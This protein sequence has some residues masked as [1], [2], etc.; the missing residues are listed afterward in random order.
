MKKLLVFMLAAA[1]LTACVD[2]PFKDIDKWPLDKAP[3]WTAGYWILFDPIL[4]SVD[5]SYWEPDTH[6]SFEPHVSTTKPIRD[7]WGVFIYQRPNSC[8]ILVTTTLDM[9]SGAKS[10]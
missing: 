5:G 1:G 6:A 10:G 7:F 2:D 3:E 8:R 9:E 4:L